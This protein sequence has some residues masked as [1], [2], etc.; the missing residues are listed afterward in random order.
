[1]HHDLPFLYHPNWCYLFIV[2]CSKRLGRP[3]MMRQESIMMRHLWRIGVTPGS[4]QPW[5]LWPRP[6]IIL[7]RAS[8][9]SISRLPT[10]S[11]VINSLKRLVFL[12]WLLCKASLFNIGPLLTSPGIAAGHEA[13]EQQR[14]A[15]DVSREATAHCNGLC[16]STVQGQMARELELR[17]PLPS[18]SP[19]PS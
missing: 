2:T 12:L 6:C 14:G 15:W 19:L 7:S 1:M 13:L 16:S 18:S 8:S 11:S 3:P 5:G 4:L 17:H 10:Q 9:S